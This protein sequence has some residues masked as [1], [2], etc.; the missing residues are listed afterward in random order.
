MKERQFNTNKYVNNKV[1]V[2]HNIWLGLCNLFQ[3]FEDLDSVK[4]KQAD[5]Q[6]VRQLL[7]EHA[8]GDSEERSC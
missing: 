6:A 3:T 5:T 7:D 4:D 1:D 2:L 8:A